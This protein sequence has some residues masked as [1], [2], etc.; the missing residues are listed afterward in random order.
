MF[1]VVPVLV[2][3][4]IVIGRFPDYQF[5][6]LRVPYLVLVILLPGVMFYLFIVSRKT[7]LL[8]E[9]I[10][11]LDRLGV[12]EVQS[13]GT[14]Q[15]GTQS[16]A[17]LSGRR[18]LMSYIRKFEAIYGSVPPE[19]LQQALRGTGAESRA[20]TIDPTAPTGPDGRTT[21]TIIPVV[22]ATFLIALGWLLIMPLQRPS[23]S[24]GDW[25]TALSLKDP[26]PLHFAFLGAYF[27]SLQ[28]L[29]RRYVLRDLR[30]SAYVAISIRIILAVTGTWVVTASAASI[31]PKLQEG[32]SLLIVGFVIGVFP[33]IVWQFVQSAFKKVTGAG[34]FLPSLRSQLP[35]SDL[36]GLTVWHEARLEEEG[37]ENVPNM[38]TADIVELMVQTRLP[39]EQ[40]IDWVDQAIL[41]TT[42]GPDGDKDQTSPRHKLRVHGIR[43]A[44][45]L[46]VSHESSTIG[47]D[48]D[49]FEKILDGGGNGTRSPIRAIVETVTTN[50]NLGLVRTWKGLADR[51]AS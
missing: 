9:F 28:M 8:N 6:A 41:F 44:S 34:F 46:Q 4:G 35:I 17:V 43:T 18:R 21:E 13:T 32:T 23:E 5:Y 12:L 19:M 26:R 22:L 47:A 11:N 31:N 1:G 24:G 3:L 36:D 38:A 10:A 37:I 2:I 49:A 45:S 20:A 29:F 27:F 39:S 33:P 50:P 51:R 40:I 14:L 15:S 42:L 25:I 48:R 30:P 7:S 16:I